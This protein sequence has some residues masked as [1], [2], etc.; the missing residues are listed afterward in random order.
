MMR[1]WDIKRTDNNPSRGCML[2]PN[3]WLFRRVILFT[4]PSS[5]S[6][7]V[8]SMFLFFRDDKRN[9]TSHYLAQVET[10][11]FAPRRNW[12]TQSIHRFFSGQEKD[13]FAL[14]H[15]YK[16]STR[17]DESWKNDV[18]SCDKSRIFSSDYPRTV[19]WLTMR[20]GFSCSFRTVDL[21]VAKRSTAGR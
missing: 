17:L 18:R 4:R 21:R 10:L 8:L 11:S 19:A 15:S 2:P 3:S 9:N 7:Q 14:Y 1:V 16:T 6:R 13:W 5:A 20:F 12:N